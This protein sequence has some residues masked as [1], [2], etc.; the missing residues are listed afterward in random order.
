MNPWAR[1]LQRT[2]WVMAGFVCLVLIGLTANAIIARSSDPVPPTKIDGLVARLNQDPKNAKLM[3][4]IQRQDVW[5][6]QTYARAEKFATV[7]F[8]LLVGGVG[9]WLLCQKWSKQLTSTPLPPDPKAPWRAL[10]QNMRAQQSIL[11]TGFVLGGGLLAV[12]VLARHDAHQAYVLDS[13]MPQAAGAPK[14]GAQPEG[15]GALPTLPPMGMAPPASAGAGGQMGAAPAVQ[16]PPMA[17]DL[18][19]SPMPVPGGTAIQPLPITP[20]GP[21]AMSPKPQTGPAAVAAALAAL[22]LPAGT[23]PFFRGTMAGVSAGSLPTSW[24]APTGKGVIWKTDVPLPGWNSPIIW[25]D[26]VFLSGGDEKTH[27][28]YAFNASDGKLAWKTSVP[29]KGKAGK[30]SPDAGQAPATLT[31][32]AT[33]VVAAFANADLAG[34]DHS[35][36]LLWTRSFGPL[37]LDY[38]Y[39]SCPVLAEGKLLVQVDQGHSPDEGKS[40]LYALDPATG[41]TLWEVKRPVMSSW[42]TPLVALLEGK[43][44]VFVA[45]NPL[46]VAYDLSSG[47][48][49]WRA[50]GMG[51]EVAPSLAFGDGRLFVAQMGAQAMAF[52]AKDGKMLWS[53]YELALP[54]ISS[55]VYAEGILYFSSPDGTL[56]ALDG[57][58]GRA[59]WEQS[60][61]RPAKTSPLAASGRILI[62]TTDGIGRVFEAG[63]TVK[64]LGD[65][66]MGET[67][68]ASPALVGDRLYVRTEKRL[69]CL[70]SP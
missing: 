3:A 22:S 43:P 32:D 66:P 54:D 41:K 1:G 61:G 15:A 45:G 37:D 53:N 20:S 26:K 12:T 28:V 52:N 9:A 51:G 13:R 50:E 10:E 17:G 6:R 62:F 8:F 29:I 64:K 39:A 65:F 49:I 38:G 21:S 19:T 18:G 48:E 46:V 11:A 44:T 63:K 2:A 4:D 36:K 25:Q 68:A 31:A 57:A 27:E 24:E 34:L 56:A 58:S 60:L 14:A 42:S 69:Y 23:W 16:P 59:H 30:L 47:K 55:P 35:G 70:G 40:K 33:H 7:G 5:L 67:V